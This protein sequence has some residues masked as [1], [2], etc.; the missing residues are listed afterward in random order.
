MLAIRPALRASVLGVL[1]LLCVAQNS[2]AA[3]KTPLLPPGKPTMSALSVR[4]KPDC[5]SAHAIALAVPMISN[6]AADI[7][8]VSTSM[9]YSRLQS[10]ER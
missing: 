2:Q 8:A 5:V 7:D 4:E 3:P 9:A 6:T 1:T 10:K